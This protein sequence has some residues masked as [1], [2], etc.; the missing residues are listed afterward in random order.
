MRGL[1]LTTGTPDTDKLVRS[2]T[3]VIPTTK[4]VRYDVS[5]VNVEAIAA[6]DRPSV[7]I[8]IGAIRQYHNAHVPDTETL[9]RTGRHA[10][11]VHLCSDAADTPW[12]PVLEEYNAANAFRLQVS[13]DGCYDSPI[14]RF[15]RVE[16]TP[17]DPACFPD[18]AP[19]GD[20]PHALGFAG[21]VGLRGDVL[22]PLRRAGAIEVLGGYGKLRYEYVCAFYSTCRLVLNDARTGTGTRRHVKGRFVEAAL[23]GALLVE[24]EDSPARDWFAPGKDYLTWGNVDDVLRH[25]RGDGRHEAMARRLRARVVERHAAP[26]FWRRTLGA[27]GL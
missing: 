19:W 17:V 26:A 18:D 13:I 3:S 8:Y 11:M 21:G 15:G 20:R 4:V 27:V 5:G 14:A 1:V 2:F 10:P 9:C 12:W 22:E 23:A 25:A 24:P 7:I 6:A 16:L